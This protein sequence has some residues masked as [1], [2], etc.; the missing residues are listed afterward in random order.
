[1]KAS[2]NRAISAFLSC[3]P[4]TALTSPTG[5]PVTSMG[6]KDFGMTPITWRPPS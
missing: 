1:M 5:S 6:I 4:E 3:M 2:A